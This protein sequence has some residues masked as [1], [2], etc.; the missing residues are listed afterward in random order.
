MLDEMKAQR[1]KKIEVGA[2]SPRPAQ[3]HKP[4]HAHAHYSLHSAPS[5]P[6]AQQTA[7][8]RSHH[9][10]WLQHTGSTVLQQPWY[11]S[12]LLSFGT[13]RHQQPPHQ[14]P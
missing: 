10:G 2:N 3:Q 12:R 9:A 8:L 14:T 4:T 13:T 1:K 11:V 6:P 5:P 7:L